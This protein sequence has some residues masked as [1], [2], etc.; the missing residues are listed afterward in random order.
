M[1]KIIWLLFFSMQIAFSQADFKKIEINTS[2]AHAELF[3]KEFLGNYFSNF[4][5]VDPER[6]LFFK[7]VIQNRLSVVYEKNSSQD[8]YP[9]LSM[10]PLFNKYNNDIKRDTDFD[11]STFNVLKYKISFFSNEPQV[12]RIDNSDYLLVV[13]PNKN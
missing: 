2:A 10:I 13:A 6:I 5:S 4:K 3:V 11:P 9:K 7:N 12:I 8:K 1:N